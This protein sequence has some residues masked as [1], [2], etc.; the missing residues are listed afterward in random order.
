MEN[1]A[2]FGRQDIDGKNAWKSIRISYI[3]YGRQRFAGEE[4]ELNSCYRSQEKTLVLLQR[5]ASASAIQGLNVPFR[6]RLVIFA[7][8]AAEQDK[9]PS[10]GA[11]TVVALNTFLSQKVS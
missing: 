5:L 8:Y 1:M 2:E 9:S 4:E 11:K 10:N 6:F 7:L 3:L